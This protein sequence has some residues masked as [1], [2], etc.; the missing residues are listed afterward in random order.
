[1]K[2]ETLQRMI[3]AVVPSYMTVHMLDGRDA[4]I[5]RIMNPIAGRFSPIGVE[6]AWDIGI[7]EFYK[8][9]HHSVRLM[10]GDKSWCEED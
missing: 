9:L 6:I 7:K 1:M 4:G 8:L 5:V 2:I 10:T 3:A